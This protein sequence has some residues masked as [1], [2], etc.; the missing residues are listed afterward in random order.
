MKYSVAFII[1][2]IWLI[3]NSCCTKVECICGDLQIP[4]SIPA[5]FQYPYEF[6]IIKTDTNFNVIDSV[7]IEFDEP[8]VSSEELYNLR[9][10]NI[11]GGQLRDF[12]YILLNTITNHRDTLKDVFYKTSTNTWVCNRCLLFFDDKLTCTIYSDVRYKF[13]NK[14]YGRNDTIHPLAK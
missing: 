10:K 8:S 7:K 4:F 6:Y 3:S 12:N 11:T 5:N 9:N 1:T 2:F 13:R 14:L